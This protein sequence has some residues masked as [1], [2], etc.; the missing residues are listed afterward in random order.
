M[1]LG[2]SV[3]ASKLCFHCFFLIIHNPVHDSI[4]VWCVCAQSYLRSVAINGDISVSM[5]AGLMLS[6]SDWLPILSAVKQASSLATV[7][8]FF[9]FLHITLRCNSLPISG[10]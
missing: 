5:W 4:C 6:Q 10:Y 8:I 2:M 9:F 3:V 7:G 1:T